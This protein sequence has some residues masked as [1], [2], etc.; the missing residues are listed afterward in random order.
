M[1]YGAIAR[2]GDTTGISGTLTALDSLIG[3]M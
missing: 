1:K 2:M 3:H